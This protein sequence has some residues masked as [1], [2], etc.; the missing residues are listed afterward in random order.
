MN[1]KYKLL[2]VLLIPVVIAASVAIMLL[3][4]VLVRMFIVLSVGTIIYMFIYLLKVKSK[5]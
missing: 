2:A 4:Y 1:L 3:R 5:Q